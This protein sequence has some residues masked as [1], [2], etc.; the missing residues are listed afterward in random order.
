MIPVPSQSKLQLRITHAV[1]A[2]ELGNEMQQLNDVDIL[3][4]RRVPELISLGFI[5]EAGGDG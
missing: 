3:M 5:D 1:A 4:H 2:L